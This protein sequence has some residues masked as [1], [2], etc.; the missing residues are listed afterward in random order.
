MRV[1]LKKEDAAPRQSALIELY[2]GTQA[3]APDNGQRCFRNVARSRKEHS[4]ST[5]GSP[6]TE[7]FDGVL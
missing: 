5:F 3:C 7:M 2:Q 6:Y 4:V 1:I